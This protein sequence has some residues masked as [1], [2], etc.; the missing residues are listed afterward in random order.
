MDYFDQTSERL[1]YRKVAET[2]VESWKDFFVDND[3]LRF[4]GMDQNGDIN[5]YAKDWISNQLTRYEKYGLGHLATI[6]KNSGKFI[7]LAGII[8]REVDGEKYMEI[9]Y[10]LKP[11]YWGKGYGT[12]MATQLK[13][14]GIQHKIADRFISIIHKENADSIR[15]AQ[16]NDMKV[17]F[18]TIYLDMEVFIFGIEQNDFYT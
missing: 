15:V 11:P 16:K 12:E 4:L 8:P 5:T 17:L 6:E 10:S 18:E 3:R 9:A 2:D 14:F 1:I 7:G 13:N